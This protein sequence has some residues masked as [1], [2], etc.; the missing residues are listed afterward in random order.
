MN[1]FG[2]KA[3][4]EFSK[5]FDNGEIQLYIAKAFDEEPN[6]HFIVCSIPHIKEVDAQQI[7]YPLVYDTEAERDEK[8]KIFN[9]AEASQFI[10][11][12]IEFIKDQKAKQNEQNEQNN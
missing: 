3:E 1:T 2:I 8:F 7:Q 10:Y 11:E 6:R 4:N 5:T 12:L 9:E